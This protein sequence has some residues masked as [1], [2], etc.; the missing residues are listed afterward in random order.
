M[1]LLVLL[2]SGRSS[3]AVTPAVLDGRW[4]VRV[5]IGSE[6]TERQTGYLLRC[7][8]PQKILVVLSRELDP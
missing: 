7:S 8:W 4:I 6:S 2:L 5:S 1:Q 3:D